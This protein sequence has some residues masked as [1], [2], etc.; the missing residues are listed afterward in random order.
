MW[1]GRAVRIAG[2]NDH[3]G[4]RDNRPDGFT[5]VGCGEARTLAANS[6]D[7]GVWKEFISRQGAKRAKKSAILRCPQSPR[8]RLRFR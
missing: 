1:F 4:P 5:I 7:R 2:R 3:Q 8:E 6:P